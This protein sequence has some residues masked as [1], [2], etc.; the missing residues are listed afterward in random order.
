MEDGTITLIGA[1]TEN[2]SFELNARAA[3][4]RERPRVPPLDDAR[5]RQLLR[6]AEADRGPSLP[7]D[8]GRARP[9]RAM[10]DGDGRAALDARRG[11]LA[12]PARRTR[13]STR[14]ALHGRRAAPRADLRQGAGGPLQSDQRAAQS[15]ARLRSR[16]RAL[17][18]RAHARC[19]ASIRSI[20][21]R[22]V[23]R[24][25][26]EDI[27]LAD[28]QALVVA[29]RRQGRLRFSGLARRRTRDR[30][31]RDLSRDGA[32]IERRLPRLRRGHARSPRRPAR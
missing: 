24:M 29:N 4:A 7:L 5:S 9:C 31:G 32:E 26:V 15:R 10:A 11:S 3:L 8:G 28:P 16:R 13:C 2:P 22:R 1:T 18:S 20:I 19:A 17:L 21:A 6:R 14:P 23:V 12:R 25:A 30:A 27:G